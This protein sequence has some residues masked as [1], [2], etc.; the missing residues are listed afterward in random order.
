MPF[1]VST[2]TASSK[3][4]VAWITDPAPYDESAPG[5]G[6]VMRT[7]LPTITGASFTL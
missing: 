2:V 7:P 3:V 6:D 1:V 5:A 4:T